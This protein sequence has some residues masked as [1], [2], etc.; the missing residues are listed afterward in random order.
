MF[1]SGCSIDSFNFLNCGDARVDAAAES[2]RFAE[3]RS[4][5][6]VLGIPF[7][8]VVR[9]LSAILLLGDVRFESRCDTQTS[10]FLR[11]L[12]LNLSLSLHLFGLP[13]YTYFF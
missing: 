7:M 1:P 6:S 3:W 4:N 12:K 5:L 10:F 11:F 2:A 9:V 13:Q 8:D